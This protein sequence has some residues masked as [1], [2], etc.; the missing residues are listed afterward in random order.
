MSNV[1]DGFQVHTSADMT[2]LSVTQVILHCLASLFRLYTYFC[3]RTSS[4]EWTHRAEESLRA[5]WDAALP[6]IYTFWHD[7]FL[8]LSLNAFCARV[9]FPVCVANDSWGGRV[10]ARIWALH[11]AP[12]V[13]IARGESREL[14]ITRIREALVRKRRLVLAADYGKPWFKARNTAQSLAMSSEGSVVAMHLRCDRSAAVG[15][16]KWR[17]QIPTPF[18]RYTLHLSRPMR[19]HAATPEA[20]AAALWSLRETARGSAPCREDPFAIE[21]AKNGSTMPGDWKTCPDLRTDH[22]QVPS[23]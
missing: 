18:N 3:Y 10:V 8:I 2:A 11:G 14:R 1:D 19:A 9:Q 22:G 16:G 6:T 5:S 13:V 4:Y 15:Y 17:V 23:T 12:V 20:I 21:C 7:E